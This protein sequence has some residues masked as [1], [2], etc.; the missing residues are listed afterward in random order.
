M[1]G[2]GGVRYKR[3]LN[4]SVVH[5]ISFHHHHQLLLL[6]YL[7]NLLL[8]PTSIIMDFVKKAAA[9][10]QGENKPAKGS[11]QQTT[12]Q[13]TGS[14][15][16]NVQKDDYVD[17]GESPSLSSH[18]FQHLLMRHHSFLLHCRQVWL[19]HRPKHPGE[20]HRWWP[21]CL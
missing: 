13:A 17:K 16:Q 9:S 11:T 3:T 8:Q 5:L 10:F 12:D 1:G 15:G 21:K 18:L 19:Q 20:D 4:P 6:L 14:T 7:L 2:R